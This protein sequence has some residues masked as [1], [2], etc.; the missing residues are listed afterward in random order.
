MTRPRQELIAELARQAA[1]VRRRRPALLVATGWWLG[2][3][4]FAVL[5]VLAVGATRP[6]AF[7]QLATHPQ[8]LLESLAGL[9]ASLLLAWF[10]FADAV[11]GR[12]RPGLLVAGLVLAAAWV[13][14]YVAGLEYPALEPGMLGKR[15]LCYL[16]TLL[17]AAPPA[18]A[19]I[20]LSRRYYVLMPLR[21]T[22]VLTLAAGMVPALFMQVACMYD[23]AHILSHHVLPIPLLVAAAAMVQW[24]VI[25]RAR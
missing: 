14:A 4:A 5:A 19:G 16:E 17:Y 7:A 9:V 3:W 10:A 18:L 2:A 25:A 8:F 15:S 22:V 13:L 24:V 1:P 6:G 23:P 20:W 21:N 11:P 12:S